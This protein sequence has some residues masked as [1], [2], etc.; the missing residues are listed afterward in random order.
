MAIST[1]DNLVPMSLYR[2][3][4]KWDRNLAS[5]SDTA[6]LR[7]PRSLTISWKKRSVM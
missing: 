2:D 5:L 3:L 7:I 4:Q 6:I 1:N